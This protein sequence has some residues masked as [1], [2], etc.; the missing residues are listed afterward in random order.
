V[1]LA[2]S[3]KIPV[4]KSSAL[5]GLFKRQFR[6]PLLKLRLS[7]YRTSPLVAE[8]VYLSCDPGCSMLPAPGLGTPLETTSPTLM[9]NTW[10]AGTVQILKL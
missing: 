4:L 10:A 3:L 9:A 2:S 1:R 6:L 7:K 8:K 5:V